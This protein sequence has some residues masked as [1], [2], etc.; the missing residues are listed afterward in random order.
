MNIDRASFVR[1]D[2][3]AARLERPPACT[4]DALAILGQPGANIPQPIGL[5]RI[6]DS[7]RTGADVE[8]HVSITAGAVAQQAQA[9]GEA[10]YPIISSTTGPFAV[11]GN[12]HTRL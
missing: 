5:F 3:I 12:P 10:F 6:N 8:P 1:R 11:R 4:E 2:A 7:I 9:C